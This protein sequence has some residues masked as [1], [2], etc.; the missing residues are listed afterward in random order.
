L[1][2]AGSPIHPLYILLAVH[3]QIKEIGKK[4]YNQL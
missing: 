4:F 2:F 3:F 1:I